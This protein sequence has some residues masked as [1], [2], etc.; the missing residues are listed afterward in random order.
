M[1]D[2]SNELEWLEQLS[3]CSLEPNERGTMVS[4]FTILVERLVVGASVVLSEMFRTWPFGFECTV[5]NA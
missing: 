1:F 3:N 5:E 4:Y 2:S